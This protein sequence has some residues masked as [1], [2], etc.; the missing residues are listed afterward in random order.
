[1]NRKIGVIY[2][3]V[4]MLCEIGSAMLFTPF[5]LK[6]LGT[7][8]YGVYQLSS[9]ITAYLMLLDLGVGNAVIRYMA[10]YRTEDHKQKQREF[11]GIATVFY[12]IIAVITVIIGIFPEMLIELCR[13]IAY[14]I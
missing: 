9:Q 4:L 8:Q 6:M 10:K 3:Y 12:F 13:Y 11:L 1:M 7:S 14:N 5:L 2:S